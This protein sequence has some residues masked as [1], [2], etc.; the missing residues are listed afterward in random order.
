[1]ML[2]PTT[3]LVVQEERTLVVELDPELFYIYADVD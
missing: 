1:C 3:M 2:N